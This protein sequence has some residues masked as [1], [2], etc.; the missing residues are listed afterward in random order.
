MDLAS[1]IVAIIA[2]ILTIPGFIAYFEAK[3]KEKEEF[4]HALGNTKNRQL[5]NKFVSKADGSIRLFQST[6]AAISYC[7]EH[8]NPPSQYF[9]N[10]EKEL[11]EHP[12]WF[13]KTTIITYG[14]LIHI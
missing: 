11:S 7:N 8:L 12:E 13:E 1:L 10:K 14:I 4:K 9:T 6:L 2:C 5:F 3:S